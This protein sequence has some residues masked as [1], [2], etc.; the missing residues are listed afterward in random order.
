MGHLACALEAS[1]DGPAFEFL[2]GT[3]VTKFEKI[4]DSLHA[5]QER[6]DVRSDSRP[7]H[8]EARAPSLILRKL[9][10]GCRGRQEAVI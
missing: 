5:L 7:T 10:G 1:G 2:L 9:L 4:W 3:E 6:F 8:E